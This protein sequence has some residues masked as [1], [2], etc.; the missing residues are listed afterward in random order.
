LGVTELLIIILVIAMIFNA[1]RL[2]EIGSSLGKSFRTFK[3]GFS[4]TDQRDKE[5]DTPAA[6]R[7]VDDAGNPR[8]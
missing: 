8:P 5:E 7:D 2:P 6:S 3:A 4:G 1:K